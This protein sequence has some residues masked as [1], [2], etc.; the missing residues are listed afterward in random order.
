[1][2]RQRPT[3]WQMLRQTGDEFIED[4][5]LS[6]SAA[7]AYYSIFSIAPLLVIAVAI[8]GTLVDAN[9]VNEELGSFLKQSLGPG[10]FAVEEM[11]QSA[12]RP[13]T[14]AWVSL[15]GVAMLLFGASGVFGQLQEALNT[16]WGVKRRD[17]RGIRGFIKDRFLSFAMV[18]GTGFLLLVSMLLTASLEGAAKY[19]AS[20]F[21]TAPAIVAAMGTLV[22][23]LVVWGLFAAIFKVLPDARIRWRDVVTGSLVTAALFVAGK[24]A[25]S[26]YLGREAT[27]SAYG[28][29]GSLALVLLWVYYS[30][31]ILLFGAEFTQVRANASGRTIQPDKDAVAVGPPVAKEE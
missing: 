10:A 14:N 22:T 12:R 18:L 28:A 5:A 11:V 17:G 16:V 24:F 21:D 19:A 25:I 8:A 6:L 31:I 1:M 4:G 2:Q 15:G 20:A 13:A 7:L 27:A 23:F 26:W 9:T 29:A 30:S 3:I